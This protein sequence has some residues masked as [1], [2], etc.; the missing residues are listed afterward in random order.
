MGASGIDIITVNM[1]ILLYW[2]AELTFDESLEDPYEYTRFLMKYQDLI[3]QVEGRSLCRNKTVLRACLKALKGAGELTE[4]QKRLFFE[5]M[6]K[7]GGVRVLDALPGDV[8]DGL[9]KETLD[10][11]LEIKQASNGRCIAR[12]PKM[13]YRCTRC[14]E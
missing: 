13:W 14:Q 10:R 2:I 7:M 5:G 3:N 1:R 11:V 9:C 4:R 8:L 12:I 6:C